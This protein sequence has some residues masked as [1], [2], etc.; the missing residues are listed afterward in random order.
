[1]AQ[2]PPARVPHGA[3]LPF[4]LALKYL[5]AGVNRL[6]VEVDNQRTKGDFPPSNNLW[7]N[8]GGIS[9]VVY[10]RPVARA[11]LD[12]VLIRPELPCPTCAATVQEQATVQNPTNRAQ[13]VELAGSY[14]SLS[15]DFGTRTIPAG[16]TWS[17]QAAVIVAHPRLWTPGGRTCTR[18]A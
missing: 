15:L 1:M 6:I 17:P 13:M 5:R 11:N 18:P 14:G 2:R 3:Y 16:G 4:E 10:L 12:S 9:D 7:W 8:F